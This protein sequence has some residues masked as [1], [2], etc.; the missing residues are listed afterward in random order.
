MREEKTYSPL[1]TRL[2]DLLA[3]KKS[4]F[5]GNKPIVA[6]IVRVIDHFVAFCLE[7]LTVV[8]FKQ[9]QYNMSFI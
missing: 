8:A 4:T 3:F 1:C 9:T 2:N 5:V 6:F 7:V